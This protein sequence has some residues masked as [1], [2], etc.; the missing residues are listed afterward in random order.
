MG[1]KPARDL[2]GEDVKILTG[3]SV[4]GTFHYVTG[5]TEFSSGDP[6]M[7]EGY[8]FP[9]RLPES[10]R[11]E[12]MTLKVNGEAKPNKTDMEYDPDIIYRLRDN[13]VN[14]TFTVAIDGKDYITLNFQRAFLEPKDD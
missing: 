9:M 12:K 2:I 8:F 1:G 6:P 13:S 7:Q 10:A 5:W 3:G 14:N 4:V 11:G